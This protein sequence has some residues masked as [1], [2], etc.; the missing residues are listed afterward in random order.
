MG[1][2]DSNT[3]TFILRQSHGFYLL[4]KMTLHVNDTR[5][6]VVETVPEK[7]TLGSVR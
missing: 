2:P 4:M 6:D 7:L 3:P 5:I 1:S